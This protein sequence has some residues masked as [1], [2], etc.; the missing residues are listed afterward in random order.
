M[1][2]G[3]LNC[4][5]IRTALKKTNVGIANAWLRPIHG[6]YFKYVATS[7]TKDLC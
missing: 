3:H 2:V 7:G 1:V 4:D 5:G 6:T